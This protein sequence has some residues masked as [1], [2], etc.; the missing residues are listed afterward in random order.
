MAE[1]QEKPS[2]MFSGRRGTLSL[3]DFIG[4]YE[5]YM[6]RLARAHIFDRR[7]ALAYLPPSLQ[8]DPLKLYN[9]EYPSIMELTETLPAQPAIEAIAEQMAHVAMPA[10]YNETGDEIRPARPP[11]PY[12]PYVAPV[13]ARAE[14]PTRQVLLADPL[15]YFYTLLRREYR[16]QNPDQVL[17]LMQFARKPGESAVEMRTRMENLIEALP[18]M[19]QDNDATLKYLDQFSYDTRRRIQE[20]LRNKYN[21]VEFTF[22]QA[23]TEAI[24]QDLDYAYMDSR[25]LM[26]RKSKGKPAALPESVSSTPKT[27]E[28]GESS[29]PQ[30]RK[31][32][33]STSAA[34]PAPA[35]AVGT[36]GPA[37]NPV[38]RRCNRCGDPNHLANTCPRTD[39]Q[40]SHCQSKG[41]SGRGHMDSR[42]V[43]S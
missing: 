17:E 3:S 28:K 20:A 25:N 15:T 30:Q 23:A 4:M 43:T 39:L 34:T 6:R 41:L 33:L 10:I 37:P 27:Y 16:F 19:L 2:F 40:C 9:R 26:G 31:S 24:A 29:R 36:T 5:G 21:G 7:L 1:A 14:Q 22:K 18:D 11:I 38:Q 12:L 13:A 35:M 8:G 42:C 32:K